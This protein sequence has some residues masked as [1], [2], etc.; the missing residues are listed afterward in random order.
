MLVETPESV[1]ACVYQ[2][3]VITLAVRVY[4]KT[5][6]CRFL[7]VCGSSSVKFEWQFWARPNICLAQQLVHDSRW[8]SEEE[9]EHNKHASY[10]S[11]MCSSL[12]T[13][14]SGQ[15]SRARQGSL[16]VQLTLQQISS[17]YLPNFLLNPTLGILDNLWQGVPHSFNPLYT[18]NHFTMFT[19]KTFPLGFILNMSILV[20]RKMVN[21]LCLCMFFTLSV[22]CQ[23]LSYFFHSYLS[24]RLEGFCTLY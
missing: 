14:S 7:H 24:C 22:F 11:C 2:L 12:L 18:K 5:V 8:V 16:P 6:W 23:P 21:S 13:V 20:L 1:L 4:L 10:F 19:L 9:C 17:M 15:V 3:V